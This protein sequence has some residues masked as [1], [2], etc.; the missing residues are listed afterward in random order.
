MDEVI[1]GQRCKRMSKWIN[2]YINGQTDTWMITS[3]DEWMR[4]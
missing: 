2:K 4:P 3:T 1:N